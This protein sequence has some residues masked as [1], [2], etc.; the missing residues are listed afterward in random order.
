MTTYFD[1]F[2][3]CYVSI[4]EM[5]EESQKDKLRA[6]GVF[7]F[8]KALRNISTHHSVL[9][10]IKDSKFQRPIARVVSIGVDC[11]VP[12]TAKFFVH[13]DRLNEIFDAILVERPF[14]VRTVEPARDFLRER[15]KSASTLYVADLMK[16]AISE[17]GAYVA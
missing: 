3:F 8:M 5:V 10:G 2:L 13:P 1:A 14:E 17:A 6:L 9:T 4:E 15:S 16:M 12:E 7:R 11:K